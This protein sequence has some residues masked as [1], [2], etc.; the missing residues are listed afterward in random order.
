MNCT[1]LAWAGDNLKHANYAAANASVVGLTRAVARELWP[2]G[3]TC[4]A[5]A[6][7][8]RT[9]A[10]FE[11]KAYTLANP[12]NRPYLTSRELP[13]EA[14][15]SP[16]DLGPFLVYLASDDAS[17]L[18]GSVFNVGGNNIGIYEDP[19]LKRTTAKF[20]GPWTLEEIKQQLP[21]S[22]LAGYHNRVDNSEKS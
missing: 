3:I 9:R 1:S 13:F 18:S 14:T 7:F 11:L 22:V 8:A 15:P 12:E 20:G 19:D 17:K 5:F 6:P 16:D 4:N 21:R 10:A 2:Y